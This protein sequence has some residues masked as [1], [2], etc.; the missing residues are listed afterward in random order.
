MYSRWLSVW[1]QPEQKLL[2]RLERQAIAT[3]V[4]V[5]VDQV[6]IA[7]TGQGIFQGPE[8]RA[9][10]PQSPPVV[11]HSVTATLI[12]RPL[13]WSSIIRRIEARSDSSA[14]RLAQS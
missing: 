6:V 5:A 9:G 2:I 10:G 13:A 3:R 8:P 1:M 7:G 11:F 12:G 4:A 14:V